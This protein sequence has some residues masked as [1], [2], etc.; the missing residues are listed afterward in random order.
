MQVA[1]PFA[2]RAQAA[3]RGMVGPAVN[4]LP[5]RV[6]SGGDPTLA[7]LL[8]RVRSTAAAAFQNAD[9]PLLAILHAIGRPLH[10]G[11]AGSSKPQLFQVWASIYW[12]RTPSAKCPRY[13]SCEVP[14]LA[15]ATS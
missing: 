10:A 9:A 14:G 12:P 1:S 15:P 6:R 3:T 8:R 5:M 2:G 7:E 13:T 11:A 4:T